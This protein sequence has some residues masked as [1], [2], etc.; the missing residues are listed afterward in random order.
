[1]APEIPVDTRPLDKVDEELIA[2][3]IIA[4]PE[5]DTL[6]SA[7]PTSMAVAENAMPRDF[8]APPPAAPIATSIDLPSFTLATAPL[9]AAPSGPSQ[10]LPHAQGGWEVEPTA[11]TPP[12]DIFKPMAAQLGPMPVGFDV[13]AAAAPNRVLPPTL[14]EGR[15]SRTQLM[16]A[17][18]PGKSWVGTG[19]ALV[20]LVGVGLFVWN[21]ASAPGG[22]EAASQRIAQLTQPQ[23]IA[24]APTQPANNLLS[25]PTQVANGTGP[26]GNAQ[27]EFAPPPVDPN[28]PIVAQGTEAMPEDISLFAR[29]Q[30]EVQAA[31]AEREGGA[32]PVAGVATAPTAPTAPLT[33]EQ[34]DAE[35]AE[36][37]RLLAEGDPATAPKPRQF[38]QDPDAYMDGATMQTAAATMPDGALLPPPATRGESSNRPSTATLPPPNELY[39]NNPQGLPIVAE[40]QMQEAPR[41]RQLGEFAAELFPQ[42]EPRVKVP[43]GL[44]PRMAATEFPSLD[45][46]SFVPGKGLIATANGKEGVLMVGETIEGW[47]L[48]SVSSDMAEFKAGGRSYVLTAQ[49]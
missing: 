4:G 16:N 19:V 18:R 41:I 36:Y 17:G 39:T 10:P 2:S 24:L 7:V 21:R 3:G 30:R 40:P 13:P 45:V 35:L 28:T 48:T 47:E 26:V 42:D 32:L 8:L 9:A 1:L 34:S 23:G 5:A 6:T 27:I 11:P 25:P 38:L 43:Q 22:L 37:R 31:R 49:N 29:L 46:L 33:K 12:P 15:P 44:R 20:A 14:P